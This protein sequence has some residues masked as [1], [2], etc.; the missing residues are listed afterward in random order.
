MKFFKTNILL[1]D[2]RTSD[3]F[4]MSSPT[5]SAVICL[6][7]LIIV[8]MGPRLMANRPAFKI[9]EILIFYNF[10]MVILSGYLF[11]E[12]S[13]KQFIRFFFTKSYKISFWLLVGLMAILLVVSLLIIP[14]H[15]W[16]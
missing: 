8:C 5:P 10:A 9:R 15:E 1:L 2:P 12:V 7:Y 6:L 3:L 14:V 11:Y 13:I 16:Q 4:M